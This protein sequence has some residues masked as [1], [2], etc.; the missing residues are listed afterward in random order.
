MFIGILV[1]VFIGLSQCRHR[2]AG[3]VETVY[4]LFF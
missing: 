3:I 2:F 4:A 1:I